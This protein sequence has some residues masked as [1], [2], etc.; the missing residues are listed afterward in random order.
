MSD[1]NKINISNYEMYVIDYLEGNMSRD[2]I[3]VFDQFL[4]A[5]PD[6]KNEI[7]GI[8][9]YTVNNTPVVFPDKVSL[10][11]KLIIPVNGIDENNYEN[12]FI[13]FHENDLSEI[14][15]NN[16]D[17]FLQTNNHLQKEFDLIGS[18]KISSDATVTF[19]NKKSL[20][21]KRAVTP[22]WFSSAAAIIIFVIA[23][24][25]FLKQEQN[26]NSTNYQHLAINTIES[27]T[28]HSAINT[29]VDN[30]Y[31]LPL[32]NQKFAKIITNDIIVEL[33]NNR[34][35]TT[36]TKMNSVVCQ[37]I[38]QYNEVKLYITF[39][40]SNSTIYNDAIAVL[41]KE[42]SPSIIGSIV[43]NHIKKISTSLGIDK[44]KK[45]QKADEP[46]F[47]KIVD[48]SLLVFNTITGSET[49]TEKSYN[50]NGELTSYKVRGQ[51]LMIN[52]KSPSSSSY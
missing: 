20:K 36:I 40:T 45:K 17:L 7:E 34:A 21:K 1:I 8:I 10:K 50:R 6:I 28:D 5:N 38:Q 39:P 49:D 41:P 30:S 43:N 16:V 19:R 23:F 15:K 4:I 25:W 47:V 18:L 46:T 9:D 13:A 22:I 44:K 29:T 33:P 11:A 42:K 31:V 52:R 24:S 3:S 26:N 2:D 37:N 14:E 12:I 32:R 27:K 48:N 51:E 35:V